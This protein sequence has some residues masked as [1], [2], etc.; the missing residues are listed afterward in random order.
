MT[1]CPTCGAVPRK[2]KRSTQANAY[3]WGVVVEMVAEACGYSKEEA[4]EALKH[5]LRFDPTLGPLGLV[6]STTADTTAEFQRY[7]EDCRRFAAETLGIYI[8]EP[9]EVEVAA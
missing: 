5:H 7:L 6:K 4:H 1:R 2:P 9:H 8:P 3:Y